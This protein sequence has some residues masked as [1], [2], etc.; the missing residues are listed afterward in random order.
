ML[1]VC[2]LRIGLLS[3]FSLLFQAAKLGLKKHVT[4]GKRMPPEAAHY[5]QQQSWQVVRPLVLSRAEQNK[6]CSYICSART[7]VDASLTHAAATFTIIE[8]GGKAS[9]FQSKYT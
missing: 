7:A 3:C 5:H 1:L 8:L 4:K 9:T 6:Q 2:Y